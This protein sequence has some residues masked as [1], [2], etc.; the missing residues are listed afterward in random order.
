[1][2]YP[3]KLCILVKNPYKLMS[4]EP[5]QTKAPNWYQVEYK[6]VG[7]LG[8]SLVT[9]ELLDGLYTN[10]FFVLPLE[11]KILLPQMMAWKLTGTIFTLLLTGIAVQVFVA[12]LYFAPSLKAI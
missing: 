2:A 11:N 1:M 12:G 7:A 3:F 10:T 9:Q 4:R 6:L 5:V 8:K